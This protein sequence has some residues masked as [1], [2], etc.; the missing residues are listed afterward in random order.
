MLL[1]ACATGVPADA[2]AGA[3]E[4]DWM[5]PKD[6]VTAV[7]VRDSGALQS[8]NAQDCPAGAL[9][10]AGPAIGAPVGPETSAE[11][12]SAVPAPPGAF[13]ADDREL[14]A[15]D[16]EMLR[17]FSARID[18]AASQST[19]LHQIVTAILGEP[20]LH[21]SYLRDANCSARETFRRRRGN[22]LS[23]ALLAVAVARANGLTARFCEVD[24]YPRWDRAGHLVTEI[25]HLNVR[26]WTG[27][28]QFQLDPLG[29]AECR[30]PVATTRVVSD[31]R[32]FAHY[33]SNLAVLRLEEGAAA[34]A[35]ALFD[36]ALAPASSE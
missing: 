1:L 19:R 15:V 3:G 12:P 34:D 32:A 30:G 23:F 6:G 27:M 7:G 21:L 28:A 14:L 10:A 18:A 16:D 24:T 29:A 17:F 5:K 13:P 2:P 8:A 25:R 35:Q 31:A 26:V 36:R 22:C 4:V 9:G 11:P 20:G 33:Y